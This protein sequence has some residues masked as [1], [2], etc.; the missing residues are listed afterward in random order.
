MERQLIRAGFSRPPLTLRT[1]TKYVSVGD[2]RDGFSHMNH[3]GQSHLKSPPPYFRRLGNHTAED[4]YL[5]VS[6]RG[7]GKPKVAV[8]RD[9]H[10]RG[11]C[12]TA[13]KGARC[14]RNDRKSTSKRDAIALMR[15]PVSLHSSW[16]ARMLTSRLP[17]YLHRLLARFA[18]VDV[19]HSLR[20]QSSYL[21]AVAP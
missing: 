6:D 18:V 21:V 14:L 15:H 19:T 8:R 20:L 7:N 13:R 5:S 16:Q 12:E 3:P 4:L 9:R 1:I 11:G 2:L 17:T 10:T